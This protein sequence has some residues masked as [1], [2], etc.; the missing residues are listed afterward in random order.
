MA[1]CCPT[2]GC[3]DP[4]LPPADLAHGATARRQQRSTCGAQCR[5]KISRAVRRRAASGGAIVQ[6]NSCRICPSRRRSPPQPH[7]RGSRGC[8]IAGPRTRHTTYD[9]A[10]WKRALN[11]NLVN[12]RWMV[13]VVDPAHALRLLACQFGVDR[14]APLRALGASR[15]LN[16]LVG[17]EPEPARVTI[18]P[19]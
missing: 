14:C 1:H 11:R 5:R 8:L 17:A 16:E 19:L 7:P 3:V 13:L 12:V 2:A 4:L 6:E 9:A 10:L 15:T 18:G